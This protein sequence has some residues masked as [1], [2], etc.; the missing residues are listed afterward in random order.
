MGKPSHHLPLMNKSY[1]DFPQYWV[2]R[3]NISAQQSRVA[4]LNSSCHERFSGSHLSLLVRKMRLSM[5]NDETYHTSGVRWL[6]IEFAVRY[7]SSNE[8]FK[9]KLHCS[10]MEEQCTEAIKTPCNE[11]NQFCSTAEGALV[12]WRW[13]PYILLRESSAA[14]TRGGCVS[15]CL[16]ARSRVVFTGTRRQTQRSTW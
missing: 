1:K 13:Q 7:R 15:H 8:D 4:M 6:K 14:E 5:E 11:L 16:R 12:A 2:E 3:W 9:A 10:W